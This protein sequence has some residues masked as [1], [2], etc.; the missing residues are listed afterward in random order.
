MCRTAAVEVVEG[1]RVERTCE[2]THLPAAKLAS[3]RH[4]LE[5]CVGRQTGVTADERAEQIRG[6]RGRWHDGVA[7]AWST[8]GRQG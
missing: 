2:G 7:A 5:S 8:D 4:R 6:T 3:S 1:D